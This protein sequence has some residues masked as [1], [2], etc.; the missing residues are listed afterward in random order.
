MVEEFAA[1]EKAEIVVSKFQ[2]NYTA[3][4]TLKINEIPV[5]KYGRWHSPVFIENMPR[6]L[7]FEE[8]NAIDKVKEI[9]GKK[10]S[11]KIDKSFP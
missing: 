11:K 6:L 10:R 3:G 2:Q 4:M 1:S 5:D 9:D 8:I 7:V